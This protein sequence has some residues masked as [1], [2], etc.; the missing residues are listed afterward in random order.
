MLLSYWIEGLRAIRHSNGTE[1]PIDR[2]WSA[3]S[4]PSIEQESSI[5]RPSG[6][7]RPI[8]A[9]SGRDAPP[10]GS[11]GRACGD[12]PRGQ[13]EPRAG[14]GRG[15]DGRAALPTGFRCPAGWCWPPTRAGSRDALISRGLPPALEP[16]AQAVGRA[17]CCGRASVFCSADVARGSSGLARMRTATAVA[18]RHRVSARMPR[19]DRRAR[20]SRSTGR[21]RPGSR[22]SR[23]RACACSGRHWNREPLRSITRLRMQRA[24]A[25]SVTDDLTQL[26]NSRYLSQVL[27]RE[28]KRASRS[29]RPLSLLFIDLDGFKGVND[30]HGHLAGSSAL[31]EAAAVDPHQR[32]RDRHRGAVRRRRVRAGPAR[33]RHARG[34]RWSA[35]ASGTR[36]RRTGSCGRT[37][38]TSS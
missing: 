1:T 14:A 4:R 33:H 21:R 35:S 18:G 30:T 38:W 22:G 5:S 37:A 12:C 11:C 25:L 32:P 29:G 15:G 16:A 7:R 13:C 9:A 6:P 34:P 19:P 24:E 27:R 31:V 36:L 20:W 2:D 17:G 8:A 10:A 26:Y 28:T 3:V 23:P